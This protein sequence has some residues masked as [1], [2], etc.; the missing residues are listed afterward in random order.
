MDKEEDK[1]LGKEH[2]QNFERCTRA[3]V[4]ETVVQLLYNRI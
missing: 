1:E 4:G 2:K 3:A